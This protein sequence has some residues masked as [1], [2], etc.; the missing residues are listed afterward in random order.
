MQQP[1][2][3]QNKKRDARVSVLALVI[4][5]MIP[6]TAHA[7]R[8]SLAWNASTE[9]SVTGYRLYYGTASGVYTESID[10]GASTTYTVQSLTNG[11]RYYFVV[12]AYTAA[13]LESAASNQVNGLPTNVGPSVLNP[14]NIT[15]TAGAFL[16]TISASDADF[17]EL[18][19]SATG[20]PAG[21][22][23]NSSTGVISGTVPAGTFT[24]TVTVSDGA[25][26]A[27]TTFTITATA[28]A[29]PTLSAVAN[30]TNDTNDVVNL[31]LS[32]AD[33]DGDVLTFSSTGLPSGLTL[34]AS[35]G[36]ITGTPASGS[37]GVSNVTV[38][39]SDG[40][41]IASRSF[42]WT[43]VD[44]NPG[45][46]AAW[47]FEEGS[48]TTVADESGNTHTGTISGAVWTTSG[49]FGNALTFDGVNDWITVAH[50]A[51][52]SLTTGMTIEAWVYPT[53]NGGG[54][55]RN[56]VI[57]ERAS[58]EVYSL[59]A[60]DETNRPLVEVFTAA[61][62]N[63]IETAT[64]GSQLPLNTWTHLATTF[65]GSTLRLFV[66]GVQVGSTALS[67][68]LLTSNGAVRIGGNNIWGGFFQGRIDEVR[69]FNVAKTAA[70]ITTDMNTPVALSDAPPAL[71]NPGNRTNAENAVISLQ[72][73]AT[74]PDGDV[75]T[76]G[77]SS[78]PPGLT[79]N[80]STGLI[81][82]TLSYSSAGT[83]TVVVTATAAGVSD[84][85]TFTWTVT[86]TDRP[87]VLTNLGN[88]TNPENAVISL[89]VVATDPD[90]DPI[91]YGATGLP[92][93]L[94][95]NASTGLISGTLSYTS[96]G[97][98]AVVVTV[99][100]G[101]ASDS[102]PFTWTVT[103]TDRAP[104]LTNP[105][106]RTNA[107]SAAVSLQL[108]A[109]D[110]DGDPITY[111]ATGL[112]PS[113]T[114]NASTGLISGTL[115]NTSAGT[116]TVV[117]TATAAGVADSKTFTWTVTST[118]GAPVLT[119][120]ANRT[121]AENAV[122][123]LQI[124]ATDPDGDPITY[125]ATGLPPSLAVNASTGLISGTLSYTSAGTHTV[126]VTATAAGASDSDTFTWTVTNTNRAPVVTDP[127][128]QTSFQGVAASIALTATDADG[129]AVTFSASGLPT[130][131][132][133]NAST[134]VVTGTPSV[135]G[136]FNPTVTASDGTATGSVTFAWTVASALPVA[137]TALTPS[138]TITSTTP[139]F[140]WSAVPN[141]GYYL[142]SI[143]DADP[144]SPTEVWIT[145]AAAS[146]P[147]VPGT[148]TM[149]A[150]RTLTRG[151]VSWSVLTWN[152]FGYGPWSAAKQAVVNAADGTLVAPS[153]V[154][155]TGPIA[156]RTPTYQWNSVAG[157]INWYQISVTD[158]LGVTRQNWTS[159]AQACADAP[160]AITPT[161]QLAE[162]PA[163]WRMRAWSAAG[164]GAWTPWTAFETAS[165]VPGV[166]AL[167]APDGAAP[168]A[169]PTFTWNAVVGVSY[170]ALRTIDKNNVASDFW[171]RPADIECPL[172]TEVCSV[173]PG[174]AIAP[175]PA[176]WQVL[177]WNAAGY[178]PW[179]DLKPFA[180]EVADPLV[181]TPATVSPTGNLGVAMATY[182]WNRVSGAAL[183]RLS[184]TVNGGAPIY[185]WHT[186]AAL[187]CATVNPC[188]VTPTSFALSTGTA[189]WKV[190]AWTNA[191]HGAWSG[192]VP[193]V[194]N[195]PVPATPVP[196]SP[197][198]A[199]AATTA[200][201]WNPAV[202]ATYYYVIVSDSTGVRIDRWVTPAQVGCA[203]GIGVC[204]LPSGLT[205]N[206]GAGSW[207]VIAYNPTGYSAWTT[208]LAF[209][210]P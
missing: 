139:A 40:S 129:Q 181:G 142:V 52:L 56:V 151:Q 165:D 106:N 166:A 194:V 79:V 115:S 96:A 10:V 201:V 163:Q 65:D 184:V 72:L 161:T 16:V 149:P 144:A 154:A 75:I 29:A 58:S 2:E 44:L 97:T 95:V 13:G 105:G 145:P 45:L 148:C 31:Q 61:Q 171:Y 64:G 33:P 183:Y 140:T 57:K 17:D 8:I 156:T 86:N 133:I 197:I 146:C 130:G 175:G 42:T 117:V 20:L 141:V 32:A 80:T 71:T 62:P 135:I 157:A 208:P 191:G 94:T 37:A 178:G 203:T 3:R 210:I 83:H 92:P 4:L 189:Q 147:S 54:A 110:P 182:R 74:D 160:C 43:V 127:G 179:S 192:A 109:T 134:G 152:T 196:V 176:Q 209:V 15:Q 55:Y 41:L 200:F 204:T 173:A 34:N 125:S 90:G 19:Y 98:H 22:A 119:N 26:Q 81:S 195:I 88:R 47:G 87:P 48:G 199:A 121:N 118:N 89:Q 100:A 168:S 193:L 138:G 23:I 9:Q 25:A 7:G 70:Q 63:V 28:N 68:S 172:G 103:N 170:Y 66:N 101:G 202:N 14:G 188:S 67:G 206:S 50:S 77:A 180:V 137:A 164:A 143:T 24:V 132:S 107:E 185:T 1:H 35:T 30:Q 122:I 198:G 186:P 38:T 167:I 155:P 82:G 153:T 91:T 85:K 51:S 174:N 126:V 111:S 84:S 128:A 6:V 21:L 59:Y 158:A 60:N 99:T 102:D 177:T 124:V 190:Q 18:T 104:V 12:K 150:P 112:P 53:A 131:L 76:Y 114:V 120:I 123:S 78:L 159:P 5:L 116:H 49:R 108:V 46:V 205:L 69:I 11:T 187:G 27:S 39:A 169:T 73:A 207:K 136:G 36:R 113:L 162:G 93:A